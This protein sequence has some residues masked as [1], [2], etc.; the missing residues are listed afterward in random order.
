MEKNA[1]RQIGK[2]YLTAKGF[3][4]ILTILRA[5]RPSDEFVMEI[6]PVKYTIDFVF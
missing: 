3:E 5:L 6:L 1:T 2:K 4:F